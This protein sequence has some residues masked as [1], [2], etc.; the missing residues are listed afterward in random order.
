MNIY[1]TEQLWVTASSVFRQSG[2]NLIIII[3]I[4]I[5]ILMI[6]IIIIII[7]MKFALTSKLLFKNETKKSPHSRVYE[8]FP[9]YRE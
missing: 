6:I 4:I 5:I 8:E 2:G 9:I 3:T 7:I 1:F